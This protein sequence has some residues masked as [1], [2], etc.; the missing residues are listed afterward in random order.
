MPIID[1]VLLQK[2]TS[3]YQ[4]DLELTLTRETGGRLW[5]CPGPP[6]PSVDLG[7]EGLVIWDLTGFSPPEVEALCQVMAAGRVGVVVASAGGDELTRRALHLCRA[8]G[9]LAL[10][11]PSPALAAAL[12][13]ALATHRRIFALEQ[14]RESLVRQLA[15]RETIERAKRVL[16]AASGV[17]ESEAMRQMQKHARDNNLKL[18]SVA[19]KLLETYKVFNGHDHK[20]GG[21]N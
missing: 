6:L 15:E 10:P 1:A 13:A 9:L 18:M 20:E 14:E 19:Q 21:E 7:A 11:A 2:P 8:L 17:S 16:M 4:A 12:E 3:A 5:R